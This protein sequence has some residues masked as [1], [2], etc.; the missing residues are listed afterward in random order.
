M[1]V[2]MIMEGMTMKN[3]ELNKNILR[4][5]SIGLA[6]TLTLM[7]TV[8]AFADDGEDGGDSSSSSSESS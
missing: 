6:A 1:V 3:N 7:P 8:T 5:I 2:V 4:A